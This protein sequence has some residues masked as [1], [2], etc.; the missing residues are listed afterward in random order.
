[1]LRLHI[2]LIAAICCFLTSFG[3]KKDSVV[4]FDA[5][6]PS[7]K[8]D[9]ECKGK[10]ERTPKPT[11]IKFKKEEL[12]AIKTVKELIKDIPEHCEVLC[13]FISIKKSDDKVFEFRNIGNEMVYADRLTQGKFILIE[14]LAT[15]C[16]TL[17]KANYKIVVEP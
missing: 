5:D 10:S 17:H 2:T 11:I 7:F 9:D 13:V 6:Y 4:V 1:M 3:Q 15:S 16:P 12:A 14:T 8:V